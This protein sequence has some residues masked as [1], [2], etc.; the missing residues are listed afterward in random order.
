M[1]DVHTDQALSHINMHITHLAVV[2]LEW[3]FRKVV[4]NGHSR[5][6]ESKDTNCQLDLR[7]KM[8]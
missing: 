3:A 1:A 7:P 6:P 2:K 4:R 8:D 5:V